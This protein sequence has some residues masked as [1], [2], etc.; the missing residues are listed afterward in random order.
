MPPRSHENHAGKSGAKLHHFHRFSKQKY[1]YFPTNFKQKKDA[2][3]SQAHPLVHNGEPPMIV[4]RR[5]TSV[6][7]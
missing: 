1:I 6:A 2:P 7:R 4:L 3:E 5:A